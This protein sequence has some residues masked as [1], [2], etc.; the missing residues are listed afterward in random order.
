MALSKLAPVVCAI[1]FAAAAPA[2]ETQFIAAATA[3]HFEAVN[4]NAFTVLMVLGD[5][6]H[7]ARAQMLV[8]PGASFATSF[9]SGTLQDVYIEVVFY[10]P[11]GR[12]TSGAVSFDSMINWNSQA[13][14]IDLV[15]SGSEAWICAGGVRL[16]ADSGLNLVPE[17]LLNSS[18]ATT[19]PLMIN[20]G[21]VP[22]ITPHDIEHDDCAPKIHGS[23]PPV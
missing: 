20:P 12:V 19:E 14:E 18:A 4:P 5:V 8:A 17:S 21:Q 7:G 23:N 6:A 3:T 22:V 2:Q 10:S 15:G 16:P 13:L 1:A 9:P 11:V